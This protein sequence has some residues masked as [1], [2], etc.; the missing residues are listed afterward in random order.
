[1]FCKKSKE[2]IKEIQPYAEKLALDTV[3]G[4]VFGGILGVFIPSRKPL[5]STMHETG[6]NFAKIS[7]AF[8]ATQMAMQKIRGKEDIYG[9]AAAGAVAGLVGSKHGGLA[10]GCVF[11]AYNAA[12]FYF[13]Q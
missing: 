12:S 9:S 8:S 7:A 13:H 4:Y 5:V 1:M 2:I 10:G 3:K 11:G 6:K